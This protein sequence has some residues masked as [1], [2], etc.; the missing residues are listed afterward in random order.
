[1]T[2]EGNVTSST[3]ST[4]V[5]SS[6]LWLPYVTLAVVCI[7]F[8]AVNFWC[9]HRRN[10]MRYRRKAEVLETRERVRERRVILNLVKAK[11]RTYL[12]ENDVDDKRPLEAQLCLANPMHFNGR[13]TNAQFSPVND[14]TKVDL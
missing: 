2:T 11:Y 10:R 9:Y 8:L 14:D 4:H 3:S 7:S 13:K 6:L 1:M 5:S 12:V